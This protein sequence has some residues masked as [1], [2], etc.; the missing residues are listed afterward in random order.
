LHRAGIDFKGLIL[1]YAFEN[2]RCVAILKPPV[3]KAVVESSVEVGFSHKYPIHFR[4]DRHRRG[5]VEPTKT[6]EGSAQ[7]SVMVRPCSLVKEIP[8]DIGISSPCSNLEPIRLT[9]SPIRHPY[10]DLTYLK[11]RSPRA[12]APQQPDVTIYVL[13]NI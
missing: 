11:Q 9:P 7:D 1:Q 10:L 4:S 6:A 8:T 2:L 3:S 5:V 13:N 12:K